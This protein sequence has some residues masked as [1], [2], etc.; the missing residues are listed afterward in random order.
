MH[1]ITSLLKTNIPKWLYICGFSFVIIGFTGILIEEFCND[2]W[3]NQPKEWIDLLKAKD[4][5]LSIRNYQL[6]SSDSSRIDS[7]ALSGFPE[8]WCKAL[9]EVGKLKRK[10]WSD[11]SVGA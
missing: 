7:L 10:I 8:Y 6:L 3:N 2:Q 1:D 9:K 11:N 5:L 4:S